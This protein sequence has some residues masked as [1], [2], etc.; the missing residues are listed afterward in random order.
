MFEIEQLSKYRIYIDTCSLMYPTAW[1]YVLNVLIPG[2]RSAS[3][4]VTVPSKVINELN[5]LHGRGGDT[6]LHAASGLKL[7]AAMLEAGVLELSGADDDTFVDNYFLYIF[8]K[9]RL[10]HN[11]ALVTQDKKLALDIYNLGNHQSVKGQKAI[12]LLKFN[13][14]GLV[15][16]V[17]NGASQELQ[18]ERM[19]RVGVKAE[20]PAGI[21]V[22]DAIFSVDRLANTFPRWTRRNLVGLCIDIATKVDRLHRANVLGGIDPSSIV[23][24]GDG[25]AGI[26]NVGKSQEVELEQEYYD[27]AVLLFMVLLPGKHPFSPGT[28]SGPGDKVRLLEFP[29]PLGK[30]R[31]SRRTPGAPWKYIWSHLPY[32]IKQMFYSVFNENARIPPGE[33]VGALRDYL[34]LLESG[35][36][37]DEIFPAGQKILNP[38][39]VA[40]TRCG[41][42]SVQERKWIESLEDEGKSYLCEDC[43]EM[44]R[45]ERK[46]K[47]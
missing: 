20:R 41:A 31:G 15:E 26:T 19:L 34:R 27:L 3:A 33:W 13:Q 38:C 44:V 37:S 42:V 10:K 24:Y 6:G 32:R 35:Y 5:K 39:E 47:A 46:K 30:Q 22:K 29:Y 12:L 9:L 11:L 16:W 4:S 40:C 2:L 23:V 25:T 28:G 1:S 17:F 45:Q 21:S 36:L 14:Q 18:G 43:L 8:T 7:I